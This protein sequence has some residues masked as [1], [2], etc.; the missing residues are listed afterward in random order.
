[1]FCLRWC[2]A[3]A[4]IKPYFDKQQQQQKLLQML[5]IVLTIIVWVLPLL[6]TPYAKMVPFMPSIDDCTTLSLVLSYTCMG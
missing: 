6:V 4:G 5:C 2:H 1:M 3:V